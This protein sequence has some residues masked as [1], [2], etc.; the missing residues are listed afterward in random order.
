[1]QMH[2]LAN[3]NM[4]V[5]KRRLYDTTWTIEQKLALACDNFVEAFDG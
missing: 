5:D 3:L 1:M 2:R 4:L